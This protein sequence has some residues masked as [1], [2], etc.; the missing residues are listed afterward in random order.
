MC[1]NEWVPPGA[2]ANESRVTSLF[3]DHNTPLIANSSF[4]LNLEPFRMITQLCVCVWESHIFFHAALF[5][6]YCLSLCTLTL[7]SD[8]MHDFTCWVIKQVEI[9]KDGD[10]SK[11]KKSQLQFKCSETNTFVIA[12]MH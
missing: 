3:S 4:K 7:R 1:E 9:H 12:I 10:A 11:C 8:Q 6:F 5:L 2:P